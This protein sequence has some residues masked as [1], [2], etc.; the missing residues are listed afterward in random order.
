MTSVYRRLAP[1]LLGPPSENWYLV[2]A[3]ISAL[4]AASRRFGPVAHCS[5]AWERQYSSN[6]FVA[7]LSTRSDHLSL[8]K[9]H[10]DTLL[11]EVEL[12]LPN[13]V[14]AAWATDLYVARVSPDRG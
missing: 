9:E 6:S 2:E 3:P 11:S 5:Y 4:F 8:S 10:R 12:A 13:E 7:Y 1:E 14:N